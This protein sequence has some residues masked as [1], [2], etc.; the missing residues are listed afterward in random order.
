MIYLQISARFG[1]GHITFENYETRPKV[2][3]NAGLRS[4]FLIRVKRLGVGSWHRD[5]MRLP[6]PPPSL[7]IGPSDGSD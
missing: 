5:Q 3:M 1:Q 7:C 4:L 2:S 6:E